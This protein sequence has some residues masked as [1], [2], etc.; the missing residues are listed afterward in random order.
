MSDTTQEPRSSGE[1]SSKYRSAAYSQVSLARLGVSEHARDLADAARGLVP[2]TCDAHAGDGEFVKDAAHLVEVARLL[3]ESAVVYERIKGTSWEQIGTALDRV[4]RQAAHERYARAEK[5]FQLRVLHA[6]LLPEHAG[7]LFTTADRLARFVAGLSTWVS[8]HRELDEIDHGD[9][10]ITAGLQ[11]M[12]TAERSA[13]I[14][15]AASLLNTME[16]R[17]AADD[18]QRHELKVG[19]CRREIELY[20]DLNVQSSDDAD[21]LAAL[22]EAR[23]RLA[24]LQADETATISIRHEIGRNR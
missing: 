21:V 11:S 15:Q 24:E 19:L 18:R 8:A 7:E 16:T 12:S 10:P 20:E 14:T 2:T 4:S 17:S 23:T 22:S 5:E 1:R 13:L 3:L 6:W 9:Q